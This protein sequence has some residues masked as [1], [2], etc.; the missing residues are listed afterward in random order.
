MKL[1]FYVQ[2][3][4]GIGHHRRA[5][6]IARALVADDFET[7]ILAGGMAVAGEDW[8]GARIVRLPSVRAA[9]TDFHTLV[10]DTDRPID[11][12][13]RNVRRDRLLACVADERP[14]ALLIES[15][16]FA[17]RQFRF[18]LL[19]LLDWAAAQRSRPLVVTSIRDILVAK[20]DPKRVA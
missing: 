20:P 11:D 9:G 4:L 16:P 5:E 19:P 12:A 8:G 2:H 13:W 7:V 6:L 10:D 15:F 3:L 1:V 14:D 17:R 18:E